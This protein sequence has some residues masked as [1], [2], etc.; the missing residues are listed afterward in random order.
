ML[1]IEP[2]ARFV[3][4]AVSA[5]ARTP[6]AARAPRVPRGA[7]SVLALAF[8]LLAGV[9]APPR[10][11][12]APASE[13]GTAG[14]EAAPLPTGERLSYRWRLGGFVGSLATLFLPGRG[15]GV[16]SLAAGGDGRATAELLITSQE[17]KR[18]EFWRYGSDIDRRTGYALEA[19]SSY[20]WRGEDKEKQEAV[21]ESGVYDMVAAIYA[22]RRRLP[23]SPE[24]MR[25]WSDGKIYPVEV[26]LRG[27]EQRDVGGRK[28]ET[29]HYTVQGDRDAPGRYWKGKLELWLA[30]DAVAT[31]VE[32]HIERSAAALR[33]ELATPP[34]G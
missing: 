20:R 16:M 33:L 14:A 32:M 15:E 19:W 22:I 30:R 3:A 4:A 23:R 17:S 26:L 5:V 1:G 6:F 12:A 34:P 10:A 8:A 18:G 24:T 27:V 9:A 13:P 11:V 28:V 7:A 29:I 21:E 31:P 2:A 25:V